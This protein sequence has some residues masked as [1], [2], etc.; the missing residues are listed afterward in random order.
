MIQILKYGEVA[1][2]DIFARTV[3]EVNVTDIVT[4]IIRNVRAEGDKALYAYC[5]KFDKAKLTSLQVSPEEI[6]EAVAS[7]EPKFLE[8]LERAAK[9]IRK[10][11]ERQVRNSFILNDEDGSVIGQ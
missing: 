11:H 9:N 6:D 8:I 2:K 1:N 5:E 10:F 4:E 7:V 3:P